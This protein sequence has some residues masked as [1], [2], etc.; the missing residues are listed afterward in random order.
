MTCAFTTADA[1]RLL[2]LAD[3]FL[4]DWAIDAVQSGERD[5]DCEARSAEWE[6]ARPVLAAAPALL[7]ALD[8]LMRALWMAGDLLCDVF[9]NAGISVAYSIGQIALNEAL[10]DASPYAEFAC[11]HQT[12]GDAE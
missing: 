7:E 9:A 4:E 11:L 8:E 1:D 12:T 10:G 2:G 5:H 3:Q 6:I